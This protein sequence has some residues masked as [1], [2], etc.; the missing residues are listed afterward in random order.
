ELHSVDPTFG[1]K[2]KPLSALTMRASFGT[3][4]RPPT[5]VQPTPGITRPLP[6][7]A[8]VTDPQRGNER[9]SDTVQYT[10]G[11]NTSLRPEESRSLSTGLIVEPALDN[12]LLRLSVDWSRIRKTD[13]ITTILFSQEI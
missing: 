13:N 9:I 10:F 7:F 6:N 5:P 1:L 3:G 4:F 12:H 11:G 2:F 8:N